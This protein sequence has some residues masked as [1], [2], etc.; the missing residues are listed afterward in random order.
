M[1]DS[2]MRPDAASPRCCGRRVSRAAKQLPEPQVFARELVDR[3]AAHQ[4]HV[5]LELCPHQAKRPLDAGLTG[6]SEGIKIKTPDPDGF[7]PKRKRLQHMG[8]ALDS[9]VHDDVDSIP[10][11]IDDL[12]QLVEGHARAVEL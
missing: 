5:A 4:L 12:S 8:P 3:S 1:G 10:H 7:G 9:S 6:G 11:D 2:T